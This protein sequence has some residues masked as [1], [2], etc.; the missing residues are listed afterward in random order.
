MRAVLLPKRSKTIFPDGEDKH[1]LRAA[2][3]KTE[4]EQTRNNQSRKAT[5]IPDG[6]AQR[7]SGLQH[8]QVA[9]STPA[10]IPNTNTNNNDK[11]TILQASPKSPERQSGSPAV[12]HRNTGQNLTED[13][14]NHAHTHRH[15]HVYSFFGSGV[16][17]NM[18]IKKITGMKIKNPVKQ[19]RKIADDTELIACYL[20]YFD[21]IIQ[22]ETRTN[23]RRFAIT[24]CI[25]VLA[26]G[27]SLIS[28]W[29]GISKKR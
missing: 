4:N 5:H 9:G 2:R 27:L 26:V 25:G 28:L 17:A 29:Q 24:T 3:P 7:Q 18:D 8:R 1:T 16:V 6:I 13:H 21:R 10:A 23:R 15:I 22:Q 12:I 19:I 20:P 11:T 14:P